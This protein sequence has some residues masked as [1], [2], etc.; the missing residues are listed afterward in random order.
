M[1]PPPIDGP[2]ADL[3]DL[4]WTLYAHRP[5][6]LHVRVRVL[7]TKEHTNAAALALRALGIKTWRAA[8]GHLR[9]HQARSVALYLL[10]FTHPR[11]DRLVREL[12]QE[13]SRLYNMR[14]SGSK[15]VPGLPEK[16]QT[17]VEQILAASRWPPP[18][19]R[20]RE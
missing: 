8:G 11:K 17:V 2:G 14:K 5:D 7:P 3:W 15:V 18:R 4:C 1:L 20:T 19:L 9:V 6:E 13:Y 16:C 12:A 10:H